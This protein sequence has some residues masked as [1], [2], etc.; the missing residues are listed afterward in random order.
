M[1]KTR[2]NAAIAMLLVMMAVLCTFTAC[3]SSTA[4]PSVEER[5]E[6][7]ASM[8]R[9]AYSGDFTYYR[10]A[11]TDVMYLDFHNP[12]AGGLTVMFD[13]ETGLPLTYTRFVELY[14]NSVTTT[15]NDFN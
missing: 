14:K 4:E 9:I 11:I 3:D 7:A 1:K 2:K 13:P 12:Y 15:P 10:D 5:V 6:M 8:R